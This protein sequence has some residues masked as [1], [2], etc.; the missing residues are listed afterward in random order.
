MSDDS[1]FLTRD[2]KFLIPMVT[3]RNTASAPETWEQACR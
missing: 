3:D 2:K 1:W